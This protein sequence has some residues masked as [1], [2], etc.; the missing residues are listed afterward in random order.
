MKQRSFG[1]S[2]AVLSGLLLVFV[3]MLLM[4]SITLVRTKLLQN[5]QNLGSSLVKSYAIEEESHLQSLKQDALMISQ[6]LEDI[7]S[8]G[9]NSSEIQGW[10]V[11]YFEKIA[12]LMNPGIVDPYAV[13]DG[14]IVAANPWEGDSTYAYQDTFWY[15]EAIAAEGEAVVSGMYVDAITNQ[16]VITISCALENGRD[17]FAMDV[18]IGNPSF[19]T[20]MNTLP[21][22]SS[23]YLCDQDGTLLYASTAWDVDQEV[24]QGYADFLVQGGRDGSLV[25]YDSIFQD[26]EGIKRSAFFY[27]MDNGWTAIVTIPVEAILMGDRNV[28]IYVMAGV[29]MILFLALVVLVVRNGLAQY[30]MR[31][32][33]ETVH[34]LGDSFYAIFRVNFKEDY[35]EAIKCHAD[36]KQELPPRGPYDRLLKVMQSRV[37][38][39]TS[40]TFETSFSLENIRQ[41]VD[42]HVSDYGGDFLRRFGDNYRWVNIR[43]LYDARIAPDEVILCFRDVDAEKRQELQQTAILEEALAQTQKS[44]QA[45]AEFFSRMSHDMRTPLNAILGCCTLAEQTGDSQKVWDYI[46]K[47]RFSGTQ[48]LELIND[49]LEISRIEVGKEQLQESRFNI[50]ELLEQTADSFRSQVQMES[51]TLEVSMEMENDFVIG[52]KKKIGQIVNNLLSNAVKYSDPGATVRLEVRQFKINKYSNYQIIVDDNGIGMSQEFMEHL[53]EPYSREVRFSAHNREGTGLGMPIVKSFVQQMNGE[54]SVT[55]KLGMGSRFT[56]TIPLEM[57]EEEQVPL[58]PA[59]GPQQEAD[60]AQAAFDWE[61]RT[62]LLAED[63]ELNQEIATEL[64]TMMGVKVLLA[65][66]GAEAVEVFARSPVNSI[67]VILMDMQ[68]PEMDGC[69]AASAIRAL[70][71]E[72]AAGVPIIAVTANAFAEDIDR[73]TKAGMNDHVSKPIDMG[74]LTSVMERL[75][76]KRKT[77]QTDTGKQTGEPV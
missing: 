53:F 36:M 42:D 1:V 35:Y 58:S 63:N 66:N 12:E 47:I 29:S 46:K 20:T 34:M 73:T 76:S 22:E 26:N 44:T 67:D 41:R 9:G 16:K 7:L 11:R 75:I 52:D 33:D 8:R 62:V 65:K 51:K 14:E 5:A 48:L 56:V 50:R 64:L 40:K 57:A 55:S 10:L 19:H 43:T 49:I 21:V 72:D 27:H 74:V 69:Q 45:K 59:E 24:L 13:I 4:Y 31:K 39:G 60:T 2:N 37:Q 17:V 28:T 32:A 71:R 70:K 54:I 18:Y 77:E 38:P 3:A 30:K 23:Y 6:Y 25:E 61:G 68:M 15:Q